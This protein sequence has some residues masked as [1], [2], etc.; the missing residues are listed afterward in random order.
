MIRGVCFAA[1]IL[2][3]GCGQKTVAVSPE[4]VIPMLGAKFITED[5][6]L[7]AVL[8]EGRVE[9]YVLYRYDRLMIQ[10]TLDTQTTGKPRTWVNPTNNA[11][12]ELRPTWTYEEYPA[13]P[14]RDY[15]LTVNHINDRKVAYGTA[16]KSH[17]GVWVETITHHI[18]T[19]S[20]KR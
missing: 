18:S 7:E 16:C 9:D 10:D 5:N 2:L 6:Q 19:Q 17:K 11:R 14:C 8:R 15:Q 1:V 12:V 4:P 13:R 3:S 20:K